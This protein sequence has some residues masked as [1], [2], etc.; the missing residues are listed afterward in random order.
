MNE[1]MN[2]SRTNLLLSVTKS[3]T[4]SNT[5]T[6]WALCLSYLPV[7]DFWFHLLSSTE[8]WRPRA[9]TPMLSEPSFNLCLHLCLTSPS[10]QSSSLLPTLALPLATTLIQLPGKFCNSALGIT[11]QQPRAN[12]RK[13]RPCSITVAP[14]CFLF[15]GQ[16]CQFSAGEGGG[17]TGKGACCQC[18]SP[19]LIPR[20]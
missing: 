6:I 7:L 17:S 9:Y 16:E 12:R 3:F 8:V 19:N 5:F 2:E 1:W 4:L 14:V 11:L 13:L 15:M 10:N 20:S 18:E